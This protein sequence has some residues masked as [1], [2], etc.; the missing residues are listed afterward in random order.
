[1]NVKRFRIALVLGVLALVF[2]LETAAQQGRTRAIEHISGDVYRATNDN[3][4]N[5]VFLVTRDGIIMGDPV[6]ADFA[7]WLKAEMASRFGVPVRYVIYAHHHWDH[8]SG[9]AVFADTAEFVGHANML[10]YLSLRAS[11]TLAAAGELDAPVAALDANG[12]GQIEREE[13]VGAGGRGA[14]FDQYDENRDGV[15]SAAEVVRGPLADV[16][17][18]TIT[19]TDEI[20]LHL[21]GQRVI[22]SWA[23]NITHSHDMSLVRFS[24]AG[25]MYFVDYIDISRLPFGTM[26]HEGGNLDGW[27]AALREAEELS[28]QAYPYVT[29]GHGDLGGPEDIT[30]FRIYVELLRDAVAT[31]IAE[32]QSLEQMRA[33]IRFEDYS[34]W[35]NYNWVGENVRGMYYLLTD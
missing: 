22:V 6:D 12:N 16:Q 2:G 4:W 17:P 21:G 14:R 31:A 18:P 13:T 9:G 29:A 7:E 25:V 30:E 20:T 10:E 33:N 19:Y 8:A 26:H 35:A 5:T 34:D 15:L 32:G 24:D 27:M 23:G 11:V 1:M 3:N 28:L